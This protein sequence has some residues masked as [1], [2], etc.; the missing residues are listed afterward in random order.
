MVGLR[1]PVQSAYSQLA[2]VSLD[3]F[4]GAEA[5]PRVGVAHVGVAVALA[6][7]REEREREADVWS[8]ED[9]F[10]NPTSPQQQCEK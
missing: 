2:L 5:L 6:R 8:H 9:S 3:P 1:L 7:C 4:R 10:Q